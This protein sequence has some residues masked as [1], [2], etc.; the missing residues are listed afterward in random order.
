MIKNILLLLRYRYFFF[1]ENKIFPFILSL[2]NQIFFPKKII[3]VY[4]LKYRDL[5]YDIFEFLIFLNIKKKLLDKNKIHIYIY[6]V[7]KFKKNKQFKKFFLEILKSFDIDFELIDKSFFTKFNN[8]KFNTFFLSD[9]VHSGNFNQWDKFNIEK[10]KNIKIIKL[11]LNCE[12]LIN[13]WLIKNNIVKNKLV[14]ITIRNNPT[15][16]QYNTEKKTNIK[17]I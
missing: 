10:L 14:T 6:S 5:S 12:N 8:F 2:K 9:T 3:G 16:T 1:V 11:N 4:N 7:N 13:E 15:S 17:F